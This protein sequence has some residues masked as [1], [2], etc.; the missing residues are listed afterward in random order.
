MSVVIFKLI[1]S[2]S[3]CKP[4]DLDIRNNSKCYAPAQS[5]VSMHHGWGLNQKLLYFL[6]TFIC[7]SAFVRLYPYSKT[8]IAAYSNFPFFMQL[9]KR[10]K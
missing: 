10:V 8:C 6:S 9:I 1:F 5:T 7:V 2:F 4:D 3:T